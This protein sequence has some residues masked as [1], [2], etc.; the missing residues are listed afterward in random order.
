M[1]CYLWNGGKGRLGWV[2]FFF[3]QCVSIYRESEKRTLSHL[4]VGI[5]AVVCG[6]LMCQGKMILSH[7][8]LCEFYN[9]N[10]G[11]MNLCYDLFLL[12]I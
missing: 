8:S 11:Q 10:S 5:W 3:L 1:N 9:P 7:F 4:P 12:L 2:F 6:A